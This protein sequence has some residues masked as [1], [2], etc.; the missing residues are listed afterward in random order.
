LPQKISYTQRDAGGASPGIA[1]A[2]I[3]SDYRIINGV[4][5]PFSI[6]KS[7]NGTPSATIT[8]QTVTLNTG[9]TDANFPV[10]TAVAQ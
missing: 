7:F 6:Q 3:F 2:G 4:L 8:I 9:L 1:V 10:Q 5:Y